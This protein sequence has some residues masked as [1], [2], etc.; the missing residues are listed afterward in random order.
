MF[1]T[2]NIRMGKKRDPSGFDHGM[3]VGARQGGLNI[4]ETDFHTHQSLE[5]AENV[6]KMRGQRK[7]ARLVKAD[8]KLTVTQITTHY[9]SGMQKSISE[10]RTPQTSKVYRL[11][12]SNKHLK[13]LGES[14]SDVCY[15]QFVQVKACIG[16]VRACVCARVCVRVCVCECVCVCVCACVC[17]SV[18]MHFS[19]NL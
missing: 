6:E 3:I 2:P 13:V 14:T 1:F 18:C 12:Q 4:S 10:H 9:N 19:G 5:F 15:R 16:S 8:R 17:M 7:R 11:Q